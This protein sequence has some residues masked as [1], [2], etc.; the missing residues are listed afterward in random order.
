MKQKNK[1]IAFLLW[2][3]FGFLGGHRF[4]LGTPLV[5]FAY[6]AAFVCFGVLEDQGQSDWSDYPAIFLFLL[7]VYDFFVVLR[8][9]GN[10]N[11]VEKTLQ[12]VAAEAGAAAAAAAEAATA[13]A[14]AVAAATATA[15]A[16]N[17]T[18]ADV[19]ASEVSS[20]SKSFEIQK[21][22]THRIVVARHQEPL[23][24]M[25]YT[26]VGHADDYEVFGAF[27]GMYADGGLFHQT[28]DG[29]SISDNA[30]TFASQFYPG[31][32]G[33]ICTALEKMRAEFE[34]YD[35]DGDLSGLS[36]SGNAFIQAG[37]ED[38]NGTVEVYSSGASEDFIYD[39]QAEWNLQFHK[40][41]NSETD[42]VSSGPVYPE[43]GITDA[44]DDLN[45]EVWD[46][47]YYHSTD[48]GTWYEVYVTET[49][50]G[51]FHD[52]SLDHEDYE[53][54]K[55]FAAMNLDH[56]QDDNQITFFVPDG[57]EDF[58]LGELTEIFI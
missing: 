20:L 47:G 38:E 19:A 15:T 21:E 17:N 25:V 5:G 37:Q 42:G 53:N 40:D 11:P 39:C 24:N 45:P 57:E 34:V 46:R 51:Y 12:Q 8:W 2:L 22:R 23:V 6:I 30:E 32:E 7:W 4:Y 52:M 49:I 31:S 41:E 9:K 13:A 28:D 56:Y 18:T 50:K 48:D 54:L 36:A 27:A 44:L 10:P 1:F 29:M 16:T 43:E 58:T 55:E 26:E 3:F 33:E 14:E 35:D